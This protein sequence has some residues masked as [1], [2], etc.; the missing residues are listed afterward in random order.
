MNLTVPTENNP[1]RFHHVGYVVASILST[2]P[3]FAASLQAEWDGNII[4]DAVQDVR[5]SFLRHSEPGSPM[6]EL[7]EP[8]S[9]NSPVASFLKKGGGLYHICYEVRSL[10]AALEYIRQTG[11]IIVRQPVP[12][13]AFN[14][15]RIAWVFTRERLLVEYLEL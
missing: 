1:S 10:Q 8:A 12:A 7:I 15:R 2:A 5:V 9:E 11:G 6:I 13:I 14:N 3:H 4:H